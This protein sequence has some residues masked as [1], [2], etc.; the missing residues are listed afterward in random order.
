M[1]FRVT[2]EQNGLTRDVTITEPDLGTNAPIRN[3]NELDA[4]A[5]PLNAV[6]TITGENDPNSRVVNVGANGVTI[7][8]VSDKEIVSCLFVN[9]PLQLEAK[10]YNDTEWQRT[11][12][13]RASRCLT[14]GRSSSTSNGN[15]Q[16]DPARPRPDRT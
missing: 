3:P 14:A 15:S 12:G 2:F 9:S 11:A 7:Q 16:L 10:K 5:D 6:C 4:N 13:H 8:R 1:Q